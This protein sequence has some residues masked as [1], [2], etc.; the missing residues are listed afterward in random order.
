MR[1]VLG[2]LGGIVTIVA[3]IPVEQLGWWTISELNTITDATRN[4]FVNAFGIYTQ[5]NN[6]TESW[7]TFYMLAG[8]FAILG[9][10]VM[11]ASSIKKK[12]AFV[13]IGGIIAIAAPVLFVLAHFNNEDLS[14]LASWFN[15]DSTFF[16]SATVLVVKYTWFL[17]VGFF[18]PILGGIMGIGS[19][20]GK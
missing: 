20:G 13:A 15:L 9:A 5:F 17:N 12:G 10:I 2:F 8:I 14:T 11:L 4:A 16:G 18:L 7:S 3:I 1:K 6:S 19:A